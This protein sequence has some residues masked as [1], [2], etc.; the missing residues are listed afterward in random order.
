MHLSGAYPDMSDTDLDALY[1]STY[2]SMKGATGQ[3]KVTWAQS[4]SLQ[5]IEILERLRNV[6]DFV[7]GL[8]GHVRFPQYDR[9]QKT[10]PSMFGGFQQSTVAQ[11]SVSESATNVATTVKDTVGKIGLG[12]A[13][14]GIAVVALL[15]FLRRK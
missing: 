8:F 3:V 4:L 11:S 9:I 12:V 1:A 15:I 7:A 10:D 13:G 2:A 14:I 5:G 6:T